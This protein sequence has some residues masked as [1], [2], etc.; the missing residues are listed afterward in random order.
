MGSASRLILFDS[1][2]YVLEPRGE[3]VADGQEPFDRSTSN[4]SNP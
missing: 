1:D 4:G 2:W 3:T